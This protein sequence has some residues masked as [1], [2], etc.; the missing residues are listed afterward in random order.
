MD[1]TTSLYRDL[2][3]REKNVKIKA[4]GIQIC[5][6]DVMDFSTSLPTKP[7]HIV[8]GTGNNSLN[9]NHLI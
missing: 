2:E 4:S 1:D 6:P 9:N 7:S 8:R 5:K 3:A